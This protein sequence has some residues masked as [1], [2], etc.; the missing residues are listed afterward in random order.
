MGQ[1]VLLTRILADALLPLHLGRLLLP[2]QRGVEELANIDAVRRRR[3][4]AST[5]A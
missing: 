1:L 3:R 5:C 2:R 4:R